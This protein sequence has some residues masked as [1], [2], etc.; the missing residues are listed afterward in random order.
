MP[1]RARLALFYIMAPSTRTSTATAPSTRTAST[2]SADAA[3]VREALLFAVRMREAQQATEEARQRV[4]AAWWR[5]FDAKRE[6]EDARKACRVAAR[7]E[8]DLRDATAFRDKL[9]DKLR[10]LGTLR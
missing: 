10:V 2:P 6:L 4:K 8:A 9:A 5:D 3:R 7:A 1:E